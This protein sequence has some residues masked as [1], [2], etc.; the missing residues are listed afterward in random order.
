MCHSESIVVVL[1]TVAE[2]YIF[3]EH[4]VL[5]NILRTWWRYQIWKHFLGYWPFVRGTHRSPMDSPHKGQWRRAL[6]CSLIC[7]WTNAWTNNWDAG[8]LR[9]HRAHYVVTVMFPAK[10]PSNTC[11][12]TSMMGLQHWQWPR[13]V[14][15]LM[16]CTCIC[17]HAL[18]IP[19]I[20]NSSKVTIE[21]YAHRRLWSLSFSENQHPKFRKAH[22]QDI[23]LNLLV[24]SY[25]SFVTYFST[26]G[27][28]F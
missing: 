3:S 23:D 10:L 18:L 5:I 25:D 28:E 13:A 1:G 9:R 7:A 12:V 26:N 27:S 20:V 14:N 17:A 4:I 8:D 19:W 15:I 16:N 21:N 2:K 22:Q 6:M 11:I 24:S